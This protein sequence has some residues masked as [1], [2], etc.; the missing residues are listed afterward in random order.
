MLLNRLAYNAITNSKLL[1]TNRKIFVLHV[2]R[3]RRI[4]NGGLVTVGLLT[5]ILGL[6]SDVTLY[7]TSQ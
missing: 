6:H 7:V 5:Y 4:L 1:P 2:R 3:G